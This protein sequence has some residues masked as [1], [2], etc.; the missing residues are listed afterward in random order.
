VTGLLQ[1]VI[2]ES[3]CVRPA[4]GE[5]RSAGYWLGVAGNQTVTAGRIL[6]ELALPVDMVATSDDWG[7]SKPD[8]RFFEQLIGSVP[9]SAA[10]ILYVGDRLDNDVRPACHAGLSTALIRRGPW[11]IIQEQDPVADQVATIR[12]AS[13]RELPER[14]AALNAAVR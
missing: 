9:Y 7:V 11:G 6:R 8:L 4:L 10:E 1:N 3:P 12:I 2:C 13:L 5:L 14:I